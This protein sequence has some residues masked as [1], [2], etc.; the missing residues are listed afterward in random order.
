MSTVIDYQRTIVGASA[1]FSAPDSIFTVKGAL[2]SEADNRN[3]PI[4]LSLSAADMKALREAGDSPPMASSHRPVHRN[5]VPSDDALYPLY[6]I[7]DGHFVH[8]RYNPSKT[9]VWTGSTM[10]G[11]SM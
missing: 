6:K 1:G 9:T 7:Q 8:R 2:W 5:D 10:Y 4:D 11:L 3:H